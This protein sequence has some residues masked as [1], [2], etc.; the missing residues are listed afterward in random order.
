VC[1]QRTSDATPLKVCIDSQALQLRQFWTV[2]LNCRKA[3]QL[4]VGRF[5][6][7]MGDKAMTRQFDQFRYAARQQQTLFDEWL[8]QLLKRLGVFGRSLTNDDA[9][10]N[11]NGIRLGG[12]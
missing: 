5:A 10:R 6:L 7:A 12:R 11:G 8:Q 1:N 4:V 2:D 3:D 9:C